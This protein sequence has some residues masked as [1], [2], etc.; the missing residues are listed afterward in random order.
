MEY[1]L[2]LVNEDTRQ[3]D[4]LNLVLEVGGVDNFG[5]QIPSRPIRQVAEVGGW[6]AGVRRCDRGVCAGLAVAVAVTER[7]VVVPGVLDVERAGASCEHREDRHSDD[8]V[9]PLTTVGW[10]FNAD[11]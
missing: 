10:R 2:N 5:A 1:P 8:R 9:R 4:V 6:N 7:R 3:G 11:G